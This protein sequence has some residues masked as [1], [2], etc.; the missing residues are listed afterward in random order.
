[1]TNY[2]V[3]WKEEK[4]K[5]CKCLQL[6][7]VI[8]CKLY[9]VKYLYFVILSVKIYT[10]NNQ[11]KLVCIYQNVSGLRMCSHM[12]GVLKLSGAD[13]GIFMGR[14][15]HILRRKTVR[16]HV[17]AKIRECLCLCKDRRGCIP[18]F[19]PFEYPWHTIPVWWGNWSL[20]FFFLIQKNQWQ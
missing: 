5:N 4:W 8:L 9:C 14:C 3:I 12:T 10:V 6:N 7:I 15:K 13:P 11:C 18:V 1:M 19:R 16:H 20:V 2:S 17:S